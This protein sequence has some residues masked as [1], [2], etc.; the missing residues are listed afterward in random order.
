MKSWLQYEVALSAHALETDASTMGAE[1]FL[2]PSLGPPSTTVESSPPSP[3][4][5]PA[6][7]PPLAQDDCPAASATWTR[8]P[9]KM[10]SRSRTPPVTLTRNSLAVLSWRTGERRGS[11]YRPRRGS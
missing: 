9:S 11:R 8:R 4:D 6:S 7:E 1:S 10:I 5:P 2:P 3:D